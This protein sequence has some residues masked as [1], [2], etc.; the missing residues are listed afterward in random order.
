MS[1]PGPFALNP[2]RKRRGN[3]GVQLSSP[4]PGAGNDQARGKPVVGYDASYHRPPP[5]PQPAL[6]AAGSG[7][8]PPTIP[9]DTTKC[10]SETE[11]RS[12]L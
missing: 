12:R 5:T 6:V 10:G 3:L 1:S 2:A 7:A 9:P 4:R 8:M 11:N